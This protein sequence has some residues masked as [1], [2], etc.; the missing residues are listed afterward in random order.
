MKNSMSHARPSI[1]GC[2]F[3]LI[4][5]G[6]SP[7]GRAQG[8]T[9]NF[10]YA[11]SVSESTAI[12]SVNADG[13]FG[14]SVSYVEGSVEFSVTDVV[15]KTNVK[16]PLI[17]GRKLKPFPINYES[18][19]NLST[20]IL[21]DVMGKWQPDV[22]VI[23][24]VYPT[25]DSFVTGTSPR[26]STGAVPAPPAISIQGNPPMLP[27]NFWNG[28]AA[29]IPGYGT[30]EVQT[31]NPSVLLP[32]DGKT[33]KYATSNGWRVSCIATLKNGVGEGF[34]VTL[35]DGATFEFDWLA[36]RPITPIQVPGAQPRQRVEMHFFA[37]KATDRFGNT[38]TYTYDVNQPNRLQS[39]VAS[40]GAAITIQ[41]NANGT[42]ASATTAGKTWQYSYQQRAN[43]TVPRVYL[44]G[45]TLPDSSAWTFYE[46]TYA[47]GSSS[48][49]VLGY[50][51][52]YSAGPY[53]SSG[54]SPVY[55]IR[56]VHPAGAVGEFY[57]KG[58][59]HGYNNLPGASCS[60]SGQAL[61]LGRPKANVVMALI[62]KTIE[63]PGVSLMD[64]SISYSPSWTYEAECASG[65]AN[66]AT[67]AITNGGKTERFTYGNDFKS[68][69]NQLLRH[70]ILQGAQ[71]LRLTEYRYLQTSTGQPF[72]DYAVGP[73]GTYLGSLENPFLR[74]NRP[75]YE[76]RIY[77]DGLIFENTVASFDHLVRPTAM[78]RA[79]SPGAPPSP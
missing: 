43:Y 21:Y 56:F 7:L 52:N 4:L 3:A 10:Q 19:Q 51:C 74:L 28:F 17:F 40:D 55:K 2:V 57:F 18:S 78:T 46:L 60:T 36:K 70:E 58:I 34:L 32:T 9:Y 38:L 33:Y 76:T 45:V 64:W 53:T 39:I 42:I 37:T 16:L 75:L 54:D 15:A 69:A 1:F 11:D 35:P 73:T 27:Y 49:I 26:C 30:Q 47:Y 50:Q 23:R 68:N 62:R 79:S 65:C 63:G 61:P 72:G 8:V 67:T 6:A 77:Q 41:Y 31:L 24:G 5:L 71:R 14:E 12:K 66:T 48:S 44:S 20:D 59:A 13:L 29:N 25:T 22:P